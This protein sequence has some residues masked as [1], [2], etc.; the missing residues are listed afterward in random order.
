MDAIDRQII[1]TKR[2]IMGNA[3]PIALS[4]LCVLNVVFLVSESGRFLNSLYEGTTYWGYIA[5]GLVEITA[6]CLIAHKPASLFGRLVRPFIIFGIFAAIVGGSAMFAVN[7]IIR[8]SR[9]A[10]IDKIKI[11]ALRAEVDKAEADAERLARQPINLAVATTRRQEASDKLLAAIEKA[12]NRSNSAGN[13]LHRSSKIGI[14]VLFRILLQ[15]SN[16]ILIGWIAD[17][18]RKVEPISTNTQL[19]EKSSKLFNWISARGEASRKQILTSKLLS[20]A[21]E[22]DQHL[23]ELINNGL[24][25]KQ[26]GGNMGDITYCP[27]GVKK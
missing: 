14:A 23:Q 18:F 2:A 27:N 7:P 21:I 24:L 3:M 5:A 12:E 20:G 4:F 13:K 8:E 10:D 26:N 6:L 19:S 15:A 16:W 17:I 1:E 11:D 25:N 9:I 22:Y